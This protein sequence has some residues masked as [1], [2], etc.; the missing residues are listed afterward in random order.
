MFCRFGALQE[1]LSDQG[2][3][4]EA[5]FFAEVCKRIGV[6]KTRMTPLHPKSDR[7]LE[8]FNQTLAKQLAIVTS[9]RQREWDRHLPVVLWAYRSAVQESTGCTPA[10]PMFGREL[11]TPVVRAFGVPPDTDL[12][13]ILRFEYLRDIQ[14]CLA[15]AHEIARQ[16]Q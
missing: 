8:R 11:E 14:Q 10:T 6:S 7:L 13:K 5:Q 12:L 3:N 15:E 4:F 1:L 9:R 2:Q 16:R